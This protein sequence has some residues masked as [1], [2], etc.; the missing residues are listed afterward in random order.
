MNG[1]T[2]DEDQDSRDQEALKEPQE[3]DEAKWNAESLRRTLIKR[4]QGH[5][6]GYT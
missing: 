1:T 4:S 6:C 3:H 5:F 2:T